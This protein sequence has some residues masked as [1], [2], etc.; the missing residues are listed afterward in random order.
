MTLLVPLLLGFL[1][2]LIGGLYLLGVFRQ[3]R[4]G[5][6]PLDKGPIPW[7]GHVFEYR[8][9][10]IKF[11]QRMKQKHG[12]VFTIQLVG[13]YITC[14]VDPLSLAA[15]VKESQEKLDFNKFAQDLAERIFGLKIPKDEKPSREPHKHLRGEGLE[16][17]TQATMCNLRNVMLQNIG[18][19]SD[20]K[21]WLEDKLFM[22]SYKTIFSASYL[23]LFGNASCKSEGSLEKAKEKDL[24][25]SDALFSMF[26]KY[27][28]LFPKLA[29]GLLLPWDKMEMER[30]KA[31]L[32]NALSIRKIK[33]KDNISRLVLDMQQVHQELGTKESMLERHMFVLLWTSQANVG[34]S[35][36]WL[37]FFL[38]KH[39][40]A[41]AAVKEEVNL[42]LKESDQDVAHG[43]HL[44]DVT[45]DMLMKT[46][47]LD[48]AIEETLR[49]IM[50][51]LLF[52][53]VL[54]DTT[55]KTADGCE[56]YMRK[57]DS[58][59]AFPYIAV[60]IDPEIHPDPHSFKYD[61]FLN[62]DGSKKTNFYKAGQKMKYYSLPWGAGLTMCPGRFFA[63][64]ELKQFIFLMMVYFDFELKNPNEKIPDADINRLGFGVI[65]PNQD[66]QFRY[67]PRF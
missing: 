38:M 7:L 10:P 8:R 40:E 5:E 18:S 37:L 59:V 30:I 54:Q 29:Y 62:P 35:A 22:F 9:H 49:L 65:H 32:W 1:A 23:S 20:K 45:Y 11:L 51:S 28:R 2:S 43:G 60:H 64:N 44:I 19:S 58:M 50:A 47:I 61:R 26:R 66:I 63:T 53:A 42:V 24:A 52:R 67:R 25:E 3:R 31:F 36:F 16:V 33:A 13:M 17:L 48:S 56:Y 46:P 57:G 4:P 55:L 34:P 15:F 14:L 41:M 27:D 12:E 21:T 6:P 39:P